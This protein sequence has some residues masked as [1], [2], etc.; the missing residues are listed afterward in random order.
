VRRKPADTFIGDSR[1]SVGPF[2]DLSSSTEVLC[3]GL[4]RKQHLQSA[5]PSSADSP[6]VQ[7]RGWLGPDAKPRDG[8]LD[9]HILPACLSFDGDEC[10]AFRRV[11]RISMNRLRGLWP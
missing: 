5:L 11:S 3:P 7:P 9:A 8:R 2:P 6:T 1:L 4:L 10:L